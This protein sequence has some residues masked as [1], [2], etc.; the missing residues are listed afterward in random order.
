MLDQGLQRLWGNEQL[1]YTRQF[2]EKTEHYV[3]QRKEIWQNL[4]IVIATILGFSVGLVSVIGGVANFY[5]KAT[6]ILQ[7]TVIL[8]GFFLI[9][10]ENEARYKREFATYKLMY[11]LT[12]INK[13]EAK[14]DFVGNEELRIGLVLAAIDNSYKEAWSREAKELFNERAKT[15]IL[16]YQDKLPSRRFFKDESPTTWNN[17]VKWLGI[18][19]HL[20]A[21][22]FYAL[23]VC[24]FVSL[25]LSILL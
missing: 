7:I 15:L 4:I 23:V 13:M 3:E 24:S 21:F 19:I 22:I 1:R 25:L 5:L 2:Q 8:Y 14:G 10:I 18:K 17:A 9:T 6:W 11:N 12:E 16:K 20:F